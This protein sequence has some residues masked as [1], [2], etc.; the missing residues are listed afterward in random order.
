MTLS[1]RRFNSFK[2]SKWATGAA[3]IIESGFCSQ[4][5]VRATFIV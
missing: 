4:I 5:A 2:T 3:T 1:A